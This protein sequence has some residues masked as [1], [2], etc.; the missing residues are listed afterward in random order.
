MKGACGKACVLLPVRCPSPDL[1]TGKVRAEPTLHLQGLDL[2]SCH[3]HIYGDFIDSSF[4]CQLLVSIFE[5]L[6]IWNIW[7]LDHISFWS[8]QFKATT[9]LGSGSHSSAPGHD[10]VRHTYV[11]KWVRDWTQAGFKPRFMWVRVMDSTEVSFWRGSNMFPHWSSV[12][13]MT[14]TREMGGFVRVLRSCGGIPD[15]GKHIKNDCHWQRKVHNIK[16]LLQ[17]CQCLWFYHPFLPFPTKTL[18]FSLLLSGHLINA[19]QQ[20]CILW[21]YSPTVKYDIWLFVLCFFSLFSTQRPA[22]LWF[23]GTWK[24]RW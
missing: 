21:N 17:T 1:R 14:T 13:W 23:G 19:A 11:V 2:S 4:P 3:L 24:H 16:F 9:F 10:Q 15:D 5:Q 20:L 22:A 7:I 6:T 8:D 12:T 18:L